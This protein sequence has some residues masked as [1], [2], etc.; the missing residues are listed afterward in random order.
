[1]NKNHFLDKIIKDWK[2]IVIC[3]GIAL[4]IY[5]AYQT[6]T[7][8]KKTFVVPLKVNATG[9]MVPSQSMES[10]RYVK[11]SVRA[12]K[13]QLATISESDFTAIIDLDYISKPG[14]T[15]IPV[16]IQPNERVLLMEP[17]EIL[18]NPE[19]I[20]LTVDESV[21][22]YIAIKP[23]LTGTP[24]YGYEVT[25]FSCRP[26]FVKASGPASVVNAVAS[27]QTESVLIDGL[28][29]SSEFVTA[30]D[31]ENSLV[32]LE[33]A[34]GEVQVSV[35]IEP[36]ILERDFSGVPIAVSNLAADFEASL[37]VPSVS[38]SAQGRLLLMETM[39]PSS[40]TSRADCSFITEEGTYEVPVTVISPV[41]VS[42]V[43]QD[44]STVTVTV[45]RIQAEAE[46]DL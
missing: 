1:M 8:D 43:S 45:T 5:L 6:T 10:Y 39:Q 36:V 40:F 38:I 4:L 25:G 46:E 32:K 2:A 17:L 42:V 7:L 21:F 18:A 15:S 20:N 11:V 44:M 31:Y 37:S 30:V 41:G 14:Q 23:T 26:E 19:Y 13:E 34:G 3:I 33:D 12:Q 27:V 16:V 35:T 29:S 22:S 28:D 9:T 24:A